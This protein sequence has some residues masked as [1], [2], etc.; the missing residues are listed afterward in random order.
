MGAVLRSIAAVMAGF[1]FMLLT[2]IVGSIVAGAFF[3][4]GGL[5]AATETP[6]AALPVMYLAANIW[7]SAI[8]A[9]FGGWLA[10][11]I[12][13]RAPYTHAIA[14]AAIVATL[15][16]G[17]AVSAVRGPSPFQPRWYGPLVSLIGVAGV[18]AGG[19]LRAAAAQAS[20]PPAP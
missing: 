20:N 14:L 17:S 6:P 5:R 12:A 2:V 1:G 3:I 4:P 10:A 8:G 13:T 19:S 11:R 15:S 18:L 9:V 16:I 7:S